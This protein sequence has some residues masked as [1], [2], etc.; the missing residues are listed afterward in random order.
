MNENNRN[1]EETIIQDGVITA[2]LI[3]GGFYRKRAAYC[4]G[5]KSPDERADELEAYCRRHLLERIYG[6]KHCHSLYRIFYYDCPPSKKAIFN[7]IT[8]KNDELSRTSNY[9]WT[10]D[11][12]DCLRRKRK[13]ALRLGELSDSNIGYYLNPQKTREILN[14]N[15]K[16]ENITESDLQ[17]NML[18][19]G[20]DM[21]IGLDIASL[22][23]KKEVNQIV[24][25]SGDSDFVPAAK[26]ARREGI[27]FILDPLGANVKDSLF[28]N[29]D[30]LNTRDNG[31]KR[32]KRFSAPNVESDNTANIESVIP[33]ESKE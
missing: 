17:L 13:F 16:V 31:F 30:G 21:R 14:G 20:V 19:K 23:Y 25:I 24:L 29:I 7:P 8:K 11:F 2:I 27:D 9:R 15:L 28:E 12:L 6:V 4:L 5:Y 3:D 32:K 1:N 10:E 33:S 22:A 26:L 18:Q